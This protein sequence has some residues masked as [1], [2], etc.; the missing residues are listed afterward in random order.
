MNQRDKNI[1]LFI[2]KIKKKYIFSHKEKEAIL[3][4][5]FL[6]GGLSAEII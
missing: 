2:V 3:Y 1:L 5:I 6:S 4:G